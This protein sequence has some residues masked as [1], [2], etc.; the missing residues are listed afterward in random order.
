[1]YSSGPLASLK[2]TLA[3]EDRR[4]RGIRATPDPLV[5]LLVVSAWWLWLLLLL[6][7]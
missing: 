3:F 1:M 5:A 2:T 4:G 6:V 7:L